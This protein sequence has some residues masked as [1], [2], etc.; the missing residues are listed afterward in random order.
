MRAYHIKGDLTEGSIGRHLVRLTLPMTASLFALISFQLVNAWYVSLLGTGPL[1]AF[2]FTF[3]VTYMIFSLFLGFGIATSS[4]VSRLIGE[5]R[6]EDVRRVV[7]HA[8]LTVFGL[9]LVL[10]FLGLAFV[11]PL[12][13]ALGASRAATGE[14]RTYME[15]YFGGMFFICLPIVINAALRA[16]GDA[17]TPALIIGG[18][19]LANA[20]L[21][22][23]LMFGFFGLP[24]MGLQGAA[25]GTL[26]S[27]I[28]ATLA[29]LV[30]MNRRALV[31]ARYLRDLF[32]IR[33]SWRRLLVIAL[34][35][36][37][38]SGLPSVVNAVILERLALT[39]PAAVAAFGV[40]TRVEAFCFIVMMAL[41]SGMAPLIGQNY[42]ARRFERVGET[43]R[44]AISFCVAW[45]VLVALVLGL[46]AN[47]F[48][49]LFSDQ[50]DVRGYIALY[51]LLV[52]FSYALSNMANGWA[53][54]FNALG[55]PQIAAAMLFLKLVLLMVPAILLGDAI[56]GPAGVFAAIA[57]VNLASGVGFH[58]YGRAYLIR[59]SQP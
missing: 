11:D 49:G 19:A 50:A 41:A 3:P 23:V 12:F 21:D 56:A 15:I 31:A 20:A 25:L 18:A 9:S 22:P 33:D 42:G 32:L 26:L 8:I 35:A 1:A 36:G 48:A 53:S 46:G 13:R 58:L 16:R 37:L 47:L 55:R 57:L 24:P 2:S 44:L 34:P 39:G 10:T 40:A 14:I 43:L 7:T 54:A 51:F 30:I 52:P 6:G 4:V 28:G 5:G 29:G 27:N 45:S 38:T 17:R 59:L